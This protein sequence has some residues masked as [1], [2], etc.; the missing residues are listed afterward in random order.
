M[1]LL[2]ALLV[3]LPIIILNL[4]HLHNWQIALID[5]TVQV[6][7]CFVL[8]ISVVGVLMEKTPYIWI[9]R[10]QSSCNFWFIDWLLLYVGRAQQP[11]SS[12]AD[13][14]DFIDYHARSGSDSH[15][16]PMEQKSY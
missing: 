16:V 4:E 3:N 5:V 15:D 7:C 8:G 2:A 13:G 14:H 1:A 9:N 11:I 12:S 10:N 6:F